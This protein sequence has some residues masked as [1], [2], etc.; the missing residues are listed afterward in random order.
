MDAVILNESKS[1]IKCGY[2]LKGLNT[3]GNCHE[4]GTPV[5]RSLRGDLL[6]FADDQYRDALFRGVTFIMAGI[7]VS[8]VL[9]IIGLLAGALMGRSPGIMLVINCL[10]LVGTALGLYG[11]YHYSTPDPGQL[12]SNK[13]ESPRRILRVAI[14]VSAVCSVVA[15]PLQFAFGASAN[16]NSGTPDNAAL[17]AG[18]LSLLVGLA[19]T[20]AWIVQ[21]FAAM[22]YTKWLA[23]RFPSER[24]LKRASLL[25]WLGPVL[26]VFGCGIGGLIALIMYYNMFSWMRKALI[27][28][29]A[30]EDHSDDAPLST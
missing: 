1:C 16:A 30:G 9:M 15:I 7:L 5:E 4:C 22:L 19:S 27:A 21:F 25:M 17:A 20:V 3:S 10:G 2:D 14:W 11:Y 6:R 8:L 12:G 29:R 28:I 13:G 26:F 24:I 18:L 23:P